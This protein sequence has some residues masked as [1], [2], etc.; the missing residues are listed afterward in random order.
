MSGA[1]ELYGLA[2]FPPHLQVDSFIQALPSAMTFI[3]NGNDILSFYEEELAGERVNYV[4]LWPKSRRCDKRQSLYAMIDETV[5]AHEKI[6][7]ILE[8]EPAALEAYNKFA[9]EYVQFRTVLDSRFRL[10]ELSNSFFTIYG[11]LCNPSQFSWYP[12][13]TRY[14][15]Y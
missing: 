8:R 3:V 1:V 4:S 7:R 5:N 13:I 6:I 10:N 15:C 9:S 11:I 14:G 12:T 2:A